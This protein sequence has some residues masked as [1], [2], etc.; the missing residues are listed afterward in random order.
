MLLRFL[1]CFFSSTLLLGPLLYAN[2]TH[3]NTSLGFVTKFR[4][5]I[6][7]LTV[8]T[9]APSSDDLSLTF[10]SEGMDDLP[11]LKDLLSEHDEYSQYRSSFFHNSKT[12]I[13]QL[14]PQ[15]TEKFLAKK[16][17]E[18]IYLLK[19][20][21]QTNFRDFLWSQSQTH[22]FIELAQENLK[23]KLRI[24]SK[25]PKKPYFMNI[26]RQ[27]WEVEGSDLISRALIEKVESKEHFTNIE[28]AEQVLR[29]LQSL[30]SAGLIYG[31]LS[32]RNL[33]SGP[34]HL[35][36]ID[37][38]VMYFLEDQDKQAS[39]TEVNFSNPFFEDFQ[40][41][42]KKNPTH[43]HQIHLALELRALLSK[44]LPESTWQKTRDQ[45]FLDLAN[46][47]TLKSWAEYT[48][49]LA[50]PSPPAPQKKYLLLK[51]IKKMRVG[52]REYKIKVRQ[53]LGD[54]DC[55][56]HSLASLSHNDAINRRE[57]VRRVLA[58]NRELQRKIE[59]GLAL[60][61]HEEALWHVLQSLALHAPA[62]ISTLGSLEAWANYF[63]NPCDEILC[64][65]YP[66]ADHP[67]IQVTAMLFDINIAVQVLDVSGDEPIFVPYH[68]FN[69]TGQTTTVPGTLTYHVGYV[70]YHNSASIPLDQEPIHFI[71]IQVV[72]SST[73]SSPSPS[74][75]PT[76]A[77]QLPPIL[78]HV[79]SRR[80]SVQETSPSPLTM[81]APPLPP[82]LYR[83]YTRRLSTPAK[84]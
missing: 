60:T 30:L 52:S 19:I 32:E 13:Y 22:D 84:S 9:A 8:A 1:F 29:I 21:R 48:K 5:L 67:V 80:P 44:W 81:R 71:P 59:T 26:L 69:S 7:D 70:A 75:T 76:S 82:I 12:D 10:V 65:S 25:I 79:S 47:G 77:L 15:F 83:I 37:F 17:L 11:S 36:L 23:H 56:F 27:E 34:E 49:E 20:E 72:P 68:S 33:V 46:H 42:S 43:I 63:Y 54:G 14:S 66:M 45:I 41:L 50:K 4:R 73:S 62:E 38:D 40:D 2:K 61:A 78:Y 55:F 57:F 31:D 53:V 28:K 64:E 24:V 74:P 58:K 51:N 35:V 39:L 6:A 3:T 18:K 16:G